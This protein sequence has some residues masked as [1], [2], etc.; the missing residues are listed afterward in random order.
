MAI[1][2]AIPY[3][4]TEEA[5]TRELAV[6]KIGYIGRAAAIFRVK[7]IYIYTFK[8]GESL[9]EA[10]FIKKNLEYLVTPPYLRKD[11]FGLDPDLKFAGLLQPLN[12]P[13][14]GHRKGSARV[15]DVRIGLVVRWEG[16]YSVVKIGEDA[17]VK[18]PKP[19]PI[20]SVVPVKIDSVID[21]KYYR[22]HII[23][24]TNI[25][26]GYTVEVIKLTD[27]VKLGK[28]ILTGKEGRS[29][30]EVI[31]ELS[32]LVNNGD[33]I[34]VFGSPRAGVDEIL[35]N[36]GLNDVL[37]E[38]LFINFIPNQG[39]VTVRTEEAIVA[40][41]SILNIITALNK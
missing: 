21:D 34:V 18:V 4:V 10:S 24:G 28:L 38:S 36:E 15:N 14:F 41:L 37:K 19:Y 17:Y 16:Y 30:T 20:K 32:N 7:K 13:V 8:G 1:S 31:G 9:R 27:L 6:N 22:G 35:K 3:N 25:Y 33:V 26:M 5:P 29:I 11:L 40:V 12:L 39:L 23:K 2:I